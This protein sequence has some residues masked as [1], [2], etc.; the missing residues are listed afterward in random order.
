M[1]VESPDPVAGLR[2]EKTNGG[3]SLH[4][5]W[6]DT[7]HADDYVVLE[8]GVP[9]G[10]FSEVLGSASGGASGLTVPMPPGNL[11]FLVAGRNSGCVGP[12]I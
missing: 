1:V 11:F 2:L 5:T 6:A 7:A 3:S 9:G 10:S 8:D 4:L 12:R